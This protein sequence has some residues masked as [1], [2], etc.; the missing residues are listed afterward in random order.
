MWM[1][2]CPVG[3][4]VFAAEPPPLD[5]QQTMGV[6]FANLQ[7]ELPTGQGC[8]SL[9]TVTVGKF[10]QTTLGYLAQEKRRGGWSRVDYVR[11]ELDD[12]IN[13]DLMAFYSDA[14]GFPASV[15]KTLANMEKG[16]VLF[17]YTIWWGHAKDENVW[18]RGI[19]FL[20]H[21]SDGSPVAGSFRCLSTP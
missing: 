3:A 14:T 15:R 17:Q 8:V 7:V 1:I 20:V 12:E 19:Q 6:L 4:S 16:S 9:G 18:S 2:L 21:E 13:E 11:V 10:I 5:E